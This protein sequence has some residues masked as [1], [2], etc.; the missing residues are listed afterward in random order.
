MRKFNAKKTKESLIKWIRDYFKENGAE[1]TKAVIGI[2]GGKDSSIAATLLVEALG[3]DRV[4]GVLMP[5]GEQSDINYSQELVE[6]LGVQSF[7]INIEKTVKALE[8][9]ARIGLKLNKVSDLG[10]VTLVN[11]PARVRMSELYAVSGFVGG[12]VVNTCNLSEDYVGYATKYGDGAGDFSPLSG[13]T[14]TEVK[15]LGRELQL[16]EKFIEKVPT[17]GLC[18]QTDED[19]LGFTYAVLDKY[20]R[21]GEIEDQA[22]KEKIDAMH[23]ANLHKLNPMPK[24]EDAVYDEVA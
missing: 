12:R 11:T 15:A 19:K 14:V 23:K 13:L 22:I 7:T 10:D 18:G 2:S 5:N 9:E 3:K 20:I 21:T 24:F 16:P 4:V 1:K 6:F 17:D 8:E